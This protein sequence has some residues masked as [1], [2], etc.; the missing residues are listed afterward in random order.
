MRKRYL[1]FLL[2]LFLFV[3]SQ[4]AEAQRVVVVC[5][6]ETHTPL[7]DVAVVTDEKYRDT[8]DY[9]GTLHLPVS[10]GEATFM[11]YGYI[12][13]TAKCEQIA[14]TVVLLP[15]MN[16]LR[17]VVVWGKDLRS[18]GLSVMLGG[19]QRSISEMPRA[20]TGVSFDAAAL[21]DRRGRRDKRHLE[22]AKEVLKEWDEKN[23]TGFDGR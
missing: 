2:S 3:V 6:I 20:K 10:F 12:A 8:T 16:A 22:K 17:E 23:G 19:I 9:T 18:E 14:D 1:G 4:N 21:F 15:A 13:Y 11:R 5:D 7:R